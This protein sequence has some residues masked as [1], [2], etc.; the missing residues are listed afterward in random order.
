MEGFYFAE[1]QARLFLCWLYHMSMNSDESFQVASIMK[2]GGESS[3]TCRGCAAPGK[4]EIGNQRNLGRLR[5]SF[6]GANQ[7]DYT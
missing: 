2:I 4:D 1:T 6:Q 5:Y 7:C 3:A